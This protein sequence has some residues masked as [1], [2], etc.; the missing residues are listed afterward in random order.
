MCICHVRQHAVVERTVRN[1]PLTPLDSR[2]QSIL[3][4]VVTD[5]VRTAEPVGSRALVDRYHF[6]VRSATIRNEM[7]EL[8][9]MGYL[10]Q[11]HTSAGRI[12]SDLGYRFYVDRL[13]D[14]AAIS[15]DEAATVRNSLM[16]RAE[17]DFILHETCRILSGLARYT[18]LATH[19]TVKDAVVRH[20][21]LTSIGQRKFLAV[22]VLDDGGVIHEIFELSHGSGK[23]DPVRAT[24]FLAQRLVGKTL[25]SLNA[26]NSELSNEALGMEELLSKVREFVKRELEAAEETDVHLEGTSYIMQQPEFQDVSRLETVLSALEERRALYKLFS[27]VYLGPG[28]TVIIGAEN[29]VD[30]MHECS[31]VG[32]KYRIG[33]RVAGTIGVVGPTRMDYRRAVAAVEFMARNLEQLL[34]ELRVA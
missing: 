11:P 2:K 28:V 1:L 29:P 25:S 19:P 13:M 7:A 32:A 27:S 6:G 33:D 17:M 18:S 14:Q 34:E 9:E 4:A 12:P 23:I 26:D 10:R 30:A 8:S 31:F 3:K 24:N 22:L 16:R 5:Y 21:A 20:I 15:S